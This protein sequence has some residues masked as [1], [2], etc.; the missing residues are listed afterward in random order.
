MSALSALLACGVMLQPPALPPEP[1]DGQSSAS[2]SDAE[3]QAEGGEGTTA[4][5]ALPAGLRP[6]PFP[7]E[8]TRGAAPP[9]VRTDAQ[10]ARRSIVDLRDPFDRPPTKPL[11]Q[12]QRNAAAARLLMPDLKDPF[13]PSVRKVRSQ[14][15]DVHIP[16]D[17]RDP[18]RE[19]P[20]GDGPRKPMCLET[21]ADGTVVQTPGN[22]PRTKQCEASAID[23]RDPFTREDD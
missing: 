14:T 17:I 12:Q 6:V 16:N 2:G 15:L 20:H 19:R 8:Q 5:D 11:T 4:R 1:E 7:L 13:S 9:P 10:R 23:L 22:K 21:T 18:F 3:A